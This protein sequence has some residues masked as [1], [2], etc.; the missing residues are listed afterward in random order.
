MKKLLGLAVILRIL[1]SIFIFHPDIKTIGY[2][3]SFLKH[4]VIDIY[5]HIAENK[6]DLPLKDSF[7][8]FPLTYL[9]LGVHQAVLSPILG[10]QFDA[11][12][13]NADSVGMVTDPNIFKYLLA[14]KLPYLILDIVIAF[15][16]LSYFADRKW[17]K[18]AFTLWL[19]NPFTIFIIYGFGNVDIFPVTLTLLALSFI[20]KDRKIPAALMLGLAA[21][22]KIYPLLFVPFLILTGKSFKERLSLGIIPFAVF[23]LISLPFLSPTFFESTLIS[24]LTT[25]M[26]NPG[27]NV[28]F[29]ESIIVGLM[30]LSSLFFY[31]WFKDKRPN[32]FNYWFTVLLIIFSFS[33]FHV[34]WLLW[35]APFVV[36]LAIEKE[37]FSLPLLMLAVASI[38]IPLLYQDR[39]MSISLYRIYSTWFDLLPTPFTAIQR[40]F[41]PYSLQSILHS[42]L[43]GGS[44]IVALELFKKEEKL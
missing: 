20:K 7:V 23:G 25:R 16:L 39:S 15:I 30:L 37:K 12:L 18:K 38:L 21:G 24:G 3:T 29:G 14:L 40:F 42:L 19:F 22:F 2:Q 34:A 35:I 5:S 32:M 13:S 17:G 6:K 4:G 31:A 1:V 28:G 8:Y 11:W 26:F 43:A 33:H 9:T 44:L 10:N 36:I 27:F 41:D